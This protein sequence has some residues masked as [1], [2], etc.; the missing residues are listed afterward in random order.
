MQVPL[1]LINYIRFCV[2]IITLFHVLIFFCWCILCLYPYIPRKE[3]HIIIYKKGY[4]FQFNLLPINNTIPFFSSTYIDFPLPLLRFCTL[5]KGFYPRGGRG[6]V[7]FVGI[8]HNLYGVGGLCS[9]SLVNQQCVLTAIHL[10]HRL[11]FPI[12]I[13]RCASR[14]TFSKE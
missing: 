1:L 10:C 14:R 12:Y 2:R 13:Y 4:I 9:V 6:L 8:N 7:T 3:G 5:L 11:V